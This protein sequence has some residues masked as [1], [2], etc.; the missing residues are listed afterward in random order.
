MNPFLIPFATFE[1]HNNDY[2][3]AMKSVF[4]LLPNSTYDYWK[5][6]ATISM[7]YAL[8]L[9][10]GCTDL[11]IAHYVVCL[12]GQDKMFKV[13]YEDIAI[14]VNGMEGVAEGDNVLSSYKKWAK[15]IHL[16]V[17]D[18]PDKGS[19][20]ALPQLRYEKV[21]TSELFAQHYS[22]ERRPILVSWYIHHRSFTTDIHSKPTKESGE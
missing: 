10:E 6:P 7:F 11:Y 20:L 12:V 18:R 5:E 22:P 4:D 9:E 15:S 17:S 14:M 2:T 3:D 19:I 8:S 16:C 1:W 21:C 13:S